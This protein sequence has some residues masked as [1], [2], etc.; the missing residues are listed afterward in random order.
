MRE[1]ESAI[2]EGSDYAKKR[3]DREVR[4][5]LREGRTSRSRG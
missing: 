2:A 3:K 5:D 4:N 1:N